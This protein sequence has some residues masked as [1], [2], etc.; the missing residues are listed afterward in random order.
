M[1]GLVAYSDSEEEGQHQEEEDQPMELRQPQHQQGFQPAAPTRVG[2]GSGLPSAAVLLAGGATVLPAPDFTSPAESWRSQAP[3]AAQHPA[4]L[5][6]AHP[7]SRGP[8]LPN[9]LADSKLQRRQG[10][11]VLVLVC[12]SVYV[13]HIPC[14]PTRPWPFKLLMPCRAIHLAPQRQGGQR[15]WG[16]AVPWRVAPPSAQVRRSVCHWQRLGEHVRPCEAT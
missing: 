1:Q 11:A 14:F 10:S 8:Q 6:R 4:G 2:A 12:V 5:K 16:K 9:P 3:P 15:R 13:A 7:D